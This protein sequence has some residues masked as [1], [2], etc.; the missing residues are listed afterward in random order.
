M[1]RFSACPCLRAMRLRFARGY[2]ESRLISGTGR[3]PHVGK[4]RCQAV[5]ERLEARTGKG[6][7]EIGDVEMAMGRR[8]LS[9]RGYDLDRPAGAGGDHLGNRSKRLRSPARKIEQSRRSMGYD[10][11]NEVDGV[12]DVQM[13]A[14]LFTIAEQRNAPVLERLAQEAVRP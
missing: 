1:I 3:G 12:I 14:A 9:R 10:L 7:Q 13:V 2:F 6:A 8:I 11:E 5:I 4:R